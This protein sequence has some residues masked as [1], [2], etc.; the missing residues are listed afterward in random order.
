MTLIE[1]LVVILILGLLGVT[2]APALVGNRD[3]KAIRGA[4]DAAESCFSHAAAKAM[5]ASNGLAV[6]LEAEPNGAGAGG[7][8]TKLSFARVPAWATGSTPIT[9]ASATTATVSLNASGLNPDDLPAPIEF[10]GIPGVFTATSASSVRCDDTL[11]NRTARNSAPP[12]ASTAAVPYVI[13]I[14][15]RPS[16]L[17]AATVLG[18]R[19]A[20]DLSSSLIGLGT[21]ASSLV[22]VS[23]L[24]IEY[25]RTGSASAAWMFRSGAG[26]IRQPL[27]PGSPIVL[28]VGLRSQAGASWVASPTEDDPGATWQSPFCRWVVVDPRNGGVRVIEAG[29][30]TGAANASAALTMSLAPVVEQ[31]ANSRQKGG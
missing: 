19:V 31:F 23:K 9:R 5:A 15:P 11:L 4:A 16:S 12:P 17:A 22:G 26:W 21:S 2:A 6:W 18:D 30:T 24:A 25:D 3:K 8:V 7:A 20:I 29:S 13:H 28:A 27:T 10:V 1:L 14:A